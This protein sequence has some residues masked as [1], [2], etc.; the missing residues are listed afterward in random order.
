KTVEALGDPLTG[1]LPPTLGPY[2]IEGLIARGGMGAVYRA[3]DPQAKRMVALKVLRGDA[4]ADL[5]TRFRLEA[6][7]VAR[8]RH[9][10]IVRVHDLGIDRG[11]RYFTMDLIDGDDLE[12]I[13][14]SGKV[15]QRE[16]ARI[17]A[18]TGDALHHAHE[19]GIIHRDVKPQ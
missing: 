3:F 7:A 8:L 14:Q 6:E 19:Q 11:A 10:H 17:V 5:A 2:K 4:D 18:E 15:P 9:P 12:K 16:L 1:A 13:I